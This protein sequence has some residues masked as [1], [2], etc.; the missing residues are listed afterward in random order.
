MVNML[1]PGL[2]EDEY[3]IQVHKNESVEHVPKN[4]VDWGL[5]YS[6]SIGKAERHDEVLIVSSSGV[7]RCLPLVTLSDA[8][9]MV[10]VAQLKFGEDNGFLKQLKSSRDEWERVPILDCYI[11]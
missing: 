6:W 9:K 8:D 5:E 2:R 1:L 4:V 7:K 10:G 3:V 11:V